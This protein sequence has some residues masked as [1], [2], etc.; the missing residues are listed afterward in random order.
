MAA[1]AL[2]LETPPPQLRGSSSS[3]GTEG[4]CSFAFSPRARG[5]LETVESE[6]EFG[7]SGP[8]SSRG[9][10]RNGCPPPFNPNSFEALVAAGAAAAAARGDT[11]CMG[12]ASSSGCTPRFSSPFP[13]ARDDAVCLVSTAAATANVGEHHLTFPPSTSETAANNKLRQKLMDVGRQFVGFENV[14]EEDTIKRR[15]ALQE[16]SQLVHNNFGRLERSLN[17]EISRRVD[18]SKTSQQLAENHATDMHDRLQK[19]I[20]DRVDC[21]ASSVEK[22]SERC[23]ALERSIAEMSG[24]WPS[25][26]EVGAATLVK[27]VH[28]L[29]CQMDMD[30][31][32][33][34]EQDAAHL[35]VIAEGEEAE[36][37]RLDGWRTTIAQQIETVKAETSRHAAE[38]RGAA[39]RLQSL[40]LDEIT[41]LKTALLGCSVAREKTDDE[42]VNAIGHYTSALQKG[43]AAASVPVL[44]TQ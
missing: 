7:L 12:G 37:A 19:K 11:L 23:A 1:L 10:T 31:R 18:S 27:E 44:L 40:C 8:R 21:L 30:R 36:E 35:Q 4:A 6:G 25:K 28:D 42:I 34:L 26:V 43:L 39:Q 16:R 2:L 9:G 5:I 20:A 33:L 14:I 41:A 29:R 3:G 17:A 22:L 15:N 38:D 13:S 24:I 32:A